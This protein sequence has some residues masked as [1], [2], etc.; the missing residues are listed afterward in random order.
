MTQPFELLQN[1]WT[2]A[3][4][5]K[6]HAAGTMSLATVDGHGRPSVRT[7][8]IKGIDERGVAFVTRA[9]SPKT[10]HFAKQPIVECCMHWATIKLQVRVRGK[11]TP[12]PEQDIEALWKVRPR[13]SQILYHLQ[14]AQSQ[15][16]PSFN[17]LLRKMA[18][19]KQ[20][21]R[22][23]KVIPPSPLYVGYIIKPTQI[24]LLEHSVLRLNKRTRYTRR[25]K[26]WIKTTLAP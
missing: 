1:A 13:D 16:I 6:D 26:Q 24:E 21:W 2:Q 22:G 19:A 11:I 25:G 12:M 7:V 15:I 4:R 9:E 3:Q 23:E 17:H 5:K 14:L 18:A 20:R 8:M 10:K